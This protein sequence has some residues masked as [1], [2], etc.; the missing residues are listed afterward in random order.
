MKKKTNDSQT[1]VAEIR[2]ML[3][4]KFISLYWIPGHSGL[5]GNERAHELAQVA[6]ETTI[7]RLNKADALPM[8]VIHRTAMEAGSK[9]EVDLFTRS[10]SGY[11]T[12]KI[13]GALPGK[14][15]RVLYDKLKRTEASILS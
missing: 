8:T 11:Y 2:N 5:Y 15:T 4:N 10:T 14:H 9:S 6:T 3:R 13:D 7:S 1:V 12:K